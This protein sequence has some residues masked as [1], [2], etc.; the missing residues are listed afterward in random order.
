MTEAHCVHDGACSGLMEIH[1][2][3]GYHDPLSG[4]PGL[5]TKESEISQLSTA[6][7]PRLPGGHH[8]PGDSSCDRFLTM[9]DCSHL[10]LV[11]NPSYLPEVA[12]AMHMWL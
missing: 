11:G 8:R 2:K 10:N 7:L 1:P 4:G 12:L 3:C 6:S 9:P 5:N